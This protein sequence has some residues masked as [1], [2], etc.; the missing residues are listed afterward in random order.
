MPLIRIVHRFGLFLELALERATFI[1][2]SNY[3][4][5]YIVLVDNVN[6]DYDELGP[7]D[8]MK[9]LDGDSLRRP[10]ALML[11]AMDKRISS[12]LSKRTDALW[13]ITELDDGQSQ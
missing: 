5:S 7:K 11:S 4:S 3:R 10:L 8:E 12:V 13:T 6:D 2:K 1:N 9:K